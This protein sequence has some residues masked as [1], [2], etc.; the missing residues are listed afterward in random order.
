M[1]AYRT[2]TCEQ[3]RKDN[4]GE[5]V[6]VSGWVHRKRDHGNLLFLD[7]RDHYGITQCVLESDSGVFPMVDKVSQ[8]SV[9][10]VTGKV[11]ERTAE[12]INTGLPTGEVEVYISEFKVFFDFCSLLN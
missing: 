6:T 2:H 7:L 11:T 5:E 1:N 4:I 3:L 10:S 9:V 12:T 8:E